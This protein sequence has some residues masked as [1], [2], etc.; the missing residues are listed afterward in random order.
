MASLKEVKNKINGVKKTAQ[1]TKAMNMV[2]SA[3]L[4]GA[5]AKMEAFRPYSS[6]FNEA[7][8]NLSGGATT[9]RSL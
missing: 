6:K 9:D 5:Q 2:A 3:R 4:R 8:S 1:I 7:M